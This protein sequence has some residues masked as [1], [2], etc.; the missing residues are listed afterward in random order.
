MTI[1]EIER[2]NVLQIGPRKP[3]LLVT[4][5]GT[6]GGLARGCMRLLTICEVTIY[7]DIIQK[8]STQNTRRGR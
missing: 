1:T 6:E 4:V 7:S 8:A 3:A 5:F 2:S